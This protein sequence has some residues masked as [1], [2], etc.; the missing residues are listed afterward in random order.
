MREDG[1]SNRGPPTMRPYKEVKKKRLK[2]IGDQ[3]S[4]LPLKIFDLTVQGKDDWR[5]VS[6]VNDVHS[7][8]I[9]DADQPSKQVLDVTPIQMIVPVIVQGNV[10]KAKQFKNDVKNV[11]ENVVDISK[12]I[13]KIQDVDSK[14]LTQTLESLHAY[15]QP[16]KED[17]IDKI[18]VEKSVEGSLVDVSVIDTFLDD[19]FNDKHVD[20]KGLSDE[21]SQE[22]QDDAPG[23]YE[24]INIDDPHNNAKK[25]S[26]PTTRTCSW[27]TLHTTS[28][29]SRSTTQLSNALHQTSNISRCHR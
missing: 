3:T 28:S 14:N 6:K 21:K 16:R 11:S 12:P 24:N 17:N 4:K 9:N 20:I 15:D 8:H 23:N 29:L 25:N 26:L 7:N 2:K 13:S 18:L 10:P 19:I 27:T 1:W 22:S 5:K